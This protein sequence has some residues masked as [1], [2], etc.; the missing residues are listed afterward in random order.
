MYTGHIQR[1][2]VM[3]IFFDSSYTSQLAIGLKR[4]RK[5]IYLANYLLQNSPIN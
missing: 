5:I 4:E 2:I 1:W 3:S